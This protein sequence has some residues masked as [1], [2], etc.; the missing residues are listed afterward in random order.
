MSPVII[1]ETVVVQVPERALIATKLTVHHFYL[2]KIR[3]DYQ[4]VL[5]EME[6]ASEVVPADHQEELYYWCI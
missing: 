2:C 6:V 5:G 3:L 4:K 1:G